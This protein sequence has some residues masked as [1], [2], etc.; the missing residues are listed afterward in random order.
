MSELAEYYSGKTIFATGFTGAMGIVAAY[1][2]LKDTKVKRIYA[3]VRT[4]YGQCPQ[5]R[6]EKCWAQHIPLSAGQMKLDKRVIAVRG[7]ITA[8]SLLGIDKDIVDV[9]RSSVEIVLH[10]SA[11]INLKKSAK[12]LAETN[13]LG[14]LAVAEL[15]TSFSKLERFVRVRRPGAERRRLIDFSRDLHR[16]FT[17]IRTWTSLTRRYTLCS[18]RNRS[19]LLFW[20]AHRW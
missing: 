13:V 11:D 8:G 6:L 18:I 5:E 4:E 9:L 2:L 14:T 10:F 17:P 12:Q 16:R 1:K 19:L 3:L 20:L 7:D 15:L